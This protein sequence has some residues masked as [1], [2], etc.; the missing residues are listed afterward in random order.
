MMLPRTRPRLL[1]PYTHSVDPERDTRLYYAASAQTVSA[2]PPRRALAVVGVR[3]RGGTESAV[4]AK[5]LTRSQA[6]STPRSER[7]SR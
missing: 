3:E 4:F 5:G 6:A 1:K 7:S 2:F